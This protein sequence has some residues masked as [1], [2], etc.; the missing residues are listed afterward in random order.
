LFAAMRRALVLAGV[1]LAVLLAGV[2]AASAAAAPIREAKFELHEDGFL[3]VVKTEG[4]EEKLTLTLDRHGEVAF[5]ELPAELTDDS[6]K[7]RFGQFGELDYTFTPARRAGP[8]GE[9]AN[10]TFEGT[11]DFTGQNEYVKFEVPRAR[12]TLLG[13]A[14]KG[15]KGGRTAAAPRRAATEAK[16]EAAADEAFLIGHSTPPW[17]VKSLFVMEVEEKHRHRVLFDALQDEKVEGMLVARGAE[18][19]GPRGDFTWNLKA[20]TAHIDPP[21]PFTGSATYKRHPRGHA[22]WRGSLTAP[23]L[24]GEPISLAGGDFRVQLLKGSPLD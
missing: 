11:F 7:A 18:A 9:L 17:P 3:V 24:G 22:V 2:P 15:C 8:C 16:R 4:S 21:A 1:I 19:V 12:G 10:G 13:T 20:G 14:K 6:V 23:V 5:Y